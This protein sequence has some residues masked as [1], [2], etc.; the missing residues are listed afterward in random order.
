[1]SQSRFTSRAVVVALVL[2][3]FATSGCGW[4]RQ[5][6]KLYGGSAESRPLEV[7]P[8]LDTSAIGAGPAGASVTASGAQRTAAAAQA[9]VG[10]TLPG[11]REDVYNRV[12]TVLAATQGVTITSRAQLLGAYDVTFGG[13]SFLVRVTPAAGGVSVAAVDPRGLPA[14]GEAPRRL[15]ETLRS[16]LVR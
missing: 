9:S 15:I 11:T 3:T 16:Q 8:E 10:F 4:F 6:G 14:S 1:M 2:A 13:A 7:P 12:G 5:G